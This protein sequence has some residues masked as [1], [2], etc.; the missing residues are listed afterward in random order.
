M[1]ST[2]FLVLFCM[3]LNTVAQVFLKAAMNHIGKF[4][5]TVSN[6]MPVGIKVATNP[7]IIGGLIC[8]VLS[9]VV[10]L[11]V[12][13]RNEVSMAYP[14]TSIAFIL[15]ALVAYF[16]LGEQLSIVRVGGIFVIILG[17]YLLTRS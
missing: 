15:T 16:F 5:F 3:L 2:I 6:I 13:S 14:L 7:F 12:L 11:M 17:I 9:V 1:T 4:S 10:W 8:Y